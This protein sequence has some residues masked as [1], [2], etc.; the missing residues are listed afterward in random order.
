MLAARKRAATAKGRAGRLALQLAQ[1]QRQHRS[2]SR[3]LHALQAKVDMMAI[4]GGRL[5]ATLQ[6]DRQRAAATAQQPGQAEDALKVS[7][8]GCNPPVSWNCL[9]PVSLMLRSSAVAQSM[10]AALLAGRFCGVPLYS[11]S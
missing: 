10:L 2:T 4:E 5:R 6:A 1:A 9:L 8:D 7:A 3:R 11:A